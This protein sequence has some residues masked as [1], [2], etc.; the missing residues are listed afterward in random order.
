MAAADDLHLCGGGFYAPAAP[1]QHGFEQVPAGVGHQLQQGL[2]H[3][4]QRH[5]SVGG[6][7]APGQRGRDGDLR[8]APHGVA[9]FVGRHLH[10]DL[11]G[12][13]AHADLG[14]A[15]AERGLGQIHQRRGRL[16]FLA[17][18]PERRP[19]FARCLEAPG[20]EAVPRHLAQA[21]AQGQHA[22]VH[23]GPPVGLHFQAHRGVL[24]VELHHLRVDDALALHR[25]QG[26][27]KAKRHAHLEPGGFTGLVAL[28]LGQQ[29][30]AVVVFATKPQLALARHPH[31]SGRLAGV[32]HRVGGRGDQLHLAR[33]IEAGLAQ[34]QAAA[35]ALAG[36]HGAQVFGFGLVVVAVEPAHHAL[37]RGGGDA[38]NGLHLK[39]GVGRGLAIVLQRQRLKTHFLAGRHPA[40]GLDARHHGGGPQRL[41]AANRLH[42]AI[43]VGVGGLQQQLL[44]LA[45]LGHVVDGE[46]A[47]AAAVQRERQLVGNHARILAGRGFLVITAGIGV[48]ALA[49]GAEAES[50]VVAVVQRL[51]AH[52]G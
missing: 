36:A 51:A 33:L 24:A 38:R 18:V 9:F 30:D 16:V 2:V 35:V 1:L 47:R 50:L 26:R 17:L 42:F 40:L 22:H 23:V 31:R 11:V 48:L 10:V 28:F 39:A 41:G 13:R 19:P 52:Q 45:R 46:L 25:H 12:L 6:G 32:A 20:E 4:G 37:A 49:R 44:R 14:Q 27:G 3:G 43:G 8:L 29:V 21:A 34:Q 7:L 15:D 5:L